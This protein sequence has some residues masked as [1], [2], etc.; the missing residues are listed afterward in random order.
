VFTQLLENAVIHGEDTAPTVTAA[1][2]GNSVR[3]TVTDRG[4]GLPE[5]QR[6][7][8]ETGDFEDVDGSGLGVGLHLVRLLVESY[9]G[10]VE[11][12]TGGSG[13]SVTVELPRATEEGPGL[14]PNQ[15]DLSGVRPALPHL[16]VALAAALVAGVPYG[17]VSEVLGGSVAGIGVFYGTVNP[18]VGWLTHEFHSVVFGFVFVSL[19]SLAPDRYHDRVLPYV[20]V[21]VGWGFLLWLV[22]ASVVAPVWLRLLGIPAPVPSFSL[23]LLLSHLAW[24]G[25]LGLL[26]AWGYEYATPRLAEFTGALKPDVP[27][28]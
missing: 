21:G 27:G 10:T 18:V 11:T 14:R 19:V 23:R 22:A 20:T 2:T 15:A 28:T 5:R 9:G 25:S 7:L 6:A 26:T 4:P 1:A 13:T 17:I 8:L 16:T 3:V 12:E 24:G